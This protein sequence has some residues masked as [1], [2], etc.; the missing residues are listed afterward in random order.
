MR[1]HYNNAEV[2]YIMLVAHHSN[3]EIAKMNGAEDGKGDVC[4]GHWFGHHAGQHS[5]TLCSGGLDESY[6]DNHEG[7][8]S[9]T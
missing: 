6:C 2:I 5:L 4:A 9:E 1:T 8:G 3:A 7:V